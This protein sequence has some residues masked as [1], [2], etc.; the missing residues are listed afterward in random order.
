MR[1]HRKKV[2]IMNRQISAKRI[3]MMLVLSFVF[4]AVSGGFLSAGASEK[5]PSSLTPRL[6]ELL[7]QEMQS[8]H[9]ASQ[10]ILTSM[11]EGDDM[12]TAEL[13]QQIHDSFILRQSMTGEDKTDF[14][15][16]VPQ[17]FVAMDRAFHATA[18][19]LAQAARVSDREGQHAAFARMIESCTDC[20]AQFA[21]VRF[22]GFQL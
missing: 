11:I 6:Q 14:M 12:R 16:T 18:A 20:H 8:I 4:F 5:F 21:T 3:R 19:E 1:K 22:P 15:R 13:A 9:A 10:Q 7:Q 17:E 2:R